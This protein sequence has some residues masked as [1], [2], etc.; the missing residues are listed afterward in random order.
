MLRT[1]TPRSGAE[2]CM[3]SSTCWTSTQ[4]HCCS[5]RKRPSALT[6]PSQKLYKVR[7][8]KSALSLPPEHSAY[9][10]D[11]TGEHLGQVIRSRTGSAAG[12]WNPPPPPPGP[13]A[14][15][16]PAGVPATATGAAGPGGHPVASLPTRTVTE[17]RK[18]PD[19]PNKTK[20]QRNSQS[21][22]DPLY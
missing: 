12:G 21:A 13:P 11:I 19:K 2:R 3:D 15:V 1:R 9:H 20:H 18:K 6:S 16:P 4:L 14:P 22:A 7:Q 8:L 5:P 17:A 10:L